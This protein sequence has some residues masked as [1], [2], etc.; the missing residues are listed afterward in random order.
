MDGMKR[1]ALEQLS[2]WKKS[3]H[4]K[5]LLVKGARQTGKTWLLR[6]FGQRSYPGVA[7]FNFEEDPKLRGLFGGRL[8]PRRL[9]EN[10]STYQGRPIRPGKDL[11]V[12]DEIQ[13]CNEALNSLK[14]FQEEAPEYHVAAAGSL[15]GVK[16][17]SPKSFPVGKVNFL[18]LCPMTFR[19]FLDA[20]G[21]ARYRQVLENLAAFEPLPDP[22]HEELVRLLRIYYCVG[23]MPE[24]V[25][26]YAENQDLLG[27]RIIQEEIINSYV[28]DY[29]KHAPTADLPKLTQVWDS[30]PT[31]LAR[32]NK[33]FMFSAIRK[34]ARAREYENAIVW[35]EDAGLILRSFHVGAVKQTLQ[36]YVNRD[37]FKVY[38]LDVGLLGAMAGLP[39]RAVVEGDRLFTEF[40][41]ALA[42]N[43]VAQELR[44]LRNMDLFYWT[45]A[46][47]MAE[48]D[49][50]LSL[51]DG[52]VPLE[53]KAGVN[54]RSKSLS[55]YVAR[56]QPEVACRS[57]LLNF[58]R[59]DRLC[60][61]PL[62]AVSCLPRLLE[63]VLGGSILAHPITPPRSG[64]RP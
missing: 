15:L 60:N 53:V 9:V 32:E 35:L 37:F 3:R 29:A 52:I 58:Q 55:S 42:E 41:G 30:I 26:H 2:A 50:L 5:P 17:S 12:L 24:A 44:S 40:K 31:Q 20:V 62:Y 51:P 27:V 47:G 38:A 21:E 6:E 56:Y 4:R 28:L 25:A 45:A 54:P 61:I 18:D 34:S 16:L 13:A 19:E 57:T 7:Y 22:F 39:M 59:Q 36:G 11:L 23:G 64:R 48:V 49:F 63:R 8:N 33:K 14:Y 10:L 1:D 46:E 43:F